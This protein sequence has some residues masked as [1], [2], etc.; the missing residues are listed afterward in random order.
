MRIVRLICCLP[1]AVAFPAIGQLIINSPTTLW[2][3]IL[4]ASTNQA[5]YFND[6]QTGRPES[7]LVGNAT[8]PAAYINFDNARTPSLTDGTLGFRVR[9]GSD[10]PQTGTFD[11]VLLIGID[12]NNDGALDLFLGADNKGGGT[13]AI[14]IWDVGAGLN[15]SPNTTTVATPTSQK[16]YSETSLNFDFSQVSLTIEPTATV[17]DLDA[18]GSTDRFIS[19]SVPFADFVSE[20]ARLGGIALDESSSLRYVVATSAQANSI[21]EDLNGIPG[22]FDGALTWEQ[23]GGMSPG[24]HVPEPRAGVLCVLGLVVLAG[25]SPL[26]RRAPR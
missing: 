6:E 19:F 23:L 14:K 7:D 18:D 20:M 21:N 25:R 22:I 26:L 15:N 16:V 12:G 24:L 10:V 5:D 13:P 1:I 2:K 11:S 9:V 8:H 3:P 4:P 17:F